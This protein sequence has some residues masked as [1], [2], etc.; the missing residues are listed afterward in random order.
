M[1]KTEEFDLIDGQFTVKEAKI[2]EI[3]MDRC[4]HRYNQIYS[5]FNKVKV[6]HFN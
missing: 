5:I 1:K 2:R 6:T 4:K 3:W